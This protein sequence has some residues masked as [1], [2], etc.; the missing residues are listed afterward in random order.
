MEYIHFCTFIEFSEL[1]YWIGIKYFFWYL[2]L[3]DEDKELLQII[4]YFEMKRESREMKENVSHKLVKI[5]F[6]L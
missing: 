2:L 3:A 1:S 5:L 6:S 4:K